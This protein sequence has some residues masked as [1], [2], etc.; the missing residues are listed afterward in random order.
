MTN[1][2]YKEVFNV[3]WVRQEL[4]KLVEV[5]N[6]RADLTKV[7]SFLALLG[8][9][10]F[11]FWSFKTPEKTPNVVVTPSPS[12]PEICAKRDF[13]ITLEKNIQQL[14]ELKKKQGNQFP[15]KCAT[16]LNELMLIQQALGLGSNNFV[17]NV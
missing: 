6:S 9:I 1:R 17:A 3:Q 14:Q 10:G 2:I 11:T 16:Q 12:I 15:D 8:F 13:N 4:E 5:E 7:L